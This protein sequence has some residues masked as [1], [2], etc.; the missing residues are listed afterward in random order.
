MLNIILKKQTCILLHPCSVLYCW[1]CVRVY[2]YED[3]GGDEGQRFCSN[4][5][6]S[7]KE[8]GCTTILTRMNSQE[9]FFLMMCNNA[10][11]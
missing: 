3:G 1:W 11:M 10:K 8:H 5:T 2:V 6:N 9:D 4:V 7:K